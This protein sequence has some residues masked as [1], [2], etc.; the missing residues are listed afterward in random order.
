MKLCRLL[1]PLLAL[2]I[3][4]SCFGGGDTSENNTGSGSEIVGTVDSGSARVVLGE[5]RL[6]V[7]GAEIYLF[8]SNYKSL[9]GETA[10]VTT[11]S[12]GSFR[13]D[14]SE[15]EDNIGMWYLEAT[16]P[17]YSLL[18]YCD[19]KGDGEE[20]NLKT[21]KI[22]EKASL[23]VTIKTDFP[24]TTDIDYTLYLEGTRLKADGDGNALVF[25]L[26]GIPTGPPGFMHTLVLEVRDPFPVTM[27]FS[28]KIQL[29][30]GATKPLEFVVNKL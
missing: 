29:V 9:G 10:K 25:S 24:D 3:L 14:S 2:L 13:I 22:A 21:I 12:D 23:S 8:K 5:S 4:V 18:S 1:L 28:Q 16:T 15:T 7:E 19:V 26:D 11:K 30:P 20:I 17:E 6:A 27:T